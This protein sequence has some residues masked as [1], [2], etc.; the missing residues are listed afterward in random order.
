MDICIN[1]TNGNA[2][3]FTSFLA[4]KCHCKLSAVV[5]INMEC[6][7]IDDH[8]DAIL[9]IKTPN[10]ILRATAGSGKTTRVTSA[11]AD[12]TDQM[13]LCIEPRRLAAISAAVRVAAERGEKVGETVGYHVRMD[14]RMGKGTKL[15]FLTTGMFLQ[16]LCHD[17]II[18]K[19]SMVIFDEFHERTLEMDT[20]LAIC[21]N[22]QNDVRGSQALRL[23][24]MSAT[25][26]PGPIEDFLAP[27]TTYDVHAPRFPL[28]IKHLSTPSGTSFECYRHT[29]CDALQTAVLYDRGD[30]LVFLPGMADIRFAQE[31]A[32]ARFG[33]AFEYCICHASLP[34][35]AQTAILKPETTK[36]RIVFATNVAESSVTIPRVTCVI[37]TGLAK[38]KFFDSASG[39]SRLETVRISRASADQRAGR[40][41][42]IAPGLCLRLWSQTTEQQLDADM[43]PQIERLDLAQAV[44]QIYAWGLVAGPE[45]LTFLTPPHAGRL[46]DATDLL[47]RLDALTPSAFSKENSHIT[48]VGK[49]MAHLPLEPRLARWMIASLEYGC[50]TDTALLAAFLSEAPYRRGAREFFDSPDL[51]CDLA[52]LKQKL[53][54]EWAYLRREATD[55]LNAIRELPRPKEVKKTAS[56]AMARAC[57][58]LAA[59]PD[60]LAQPRQ[61]TRERLKAFTSSDPARFLQPIVAKMTPNRGV[62]IRQ[63]K[64]LTDAKYF[65]CADLDLVRNVEFASNTVLKALAVDPAWIPWKTEVRAR[66]EAEK[67]RVVIAESVCFD[68]FTLRETFIHDKKYASLEARVLYE[69]A[70]KSPFKALNFEGEAIQMLMARLAFVKKLQPDFD[71]PAL[72]ESFVEYILPDLVKR[73][74]NFEDLRNVDLCALMLDALDDMGRAMLDA[75]APTQVKL[76][77]GRFCRVDYT[78][79]PP[80]VSLK[81]QQA[82]D[83]WHVPLVGGGK[84]PVLMHLCAPNGR[85]AQVTQDMDSFWKNGYPELRKLLKARYP[86]HDWRDVTC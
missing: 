19:V 22:I 82:F 43:R 72:D 70:M 15:L 5:D 56:P 77:N 20:A 33:D 47:V 31:E 69:A 8:I 9:N 61:H 73:A 50:E 65:I 39:L 57:S 86:K 49:Q 42:R 38:E 63:G 3:V 1:D 75:L 35:E 41:A 36:R 2:C 58:M 55:I 84:I 23:V 67:D 52:L 46:S 62:A 21:R 11:F 74:H 45:A 66:Y 81:I 68:I 7:P 60:R 40:A 71:Y 17:P 10:F 34:I 30:I 48:P 28:Q 85:V 6:L 12:K 13:I 59:Y 32:H 64:T 83:T 44:L 29:L 14:K 80:V 4:I 51:E 27:C 18:E 79:D 76:E 78:N 54:P 37:D 24:V 26:E 25:I 53:P 16:Y